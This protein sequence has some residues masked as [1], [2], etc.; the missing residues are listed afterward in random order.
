LFQI[1]RTS[2]SES[3]WPRRIALTL[4]AATFPLVWVGGLVTTYDAGMAVPDWPTTYGYNPLAYP[5]MTWLYGPWDLFIEHAH[6][7]LAIA[8]GMLTIALVVAVWRSDAR[9]SMR[10]LTLLTLAAV[11]A[12]GSLGGLRVILDDTQLAMLH[13]CVGPA[14]LALT[15]VVATLLSPRWSADGPRLP[16]GPARRMRSL[17][18]LSVTLA[19]GQLV[20]GAQLRHLPVATSAQQFH[21]LVV[22]H[23]I[24]AAVLIAQIFFLAIHVRRS[25]RR[26]SWLMRPSLLLVALGLVQISLGLGTWMAKY[27]WPAW[28]PA[29]EWVQAYTV[30]AESRWQAWVTT[31]HVATGA[32]IVA[33]SA[34]MLLR[35]FHV[36]SERSVA[37]HS[38][39]AS[40]NSYHGAISTRELLEGGM[41]A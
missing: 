34:V 11:I 4:V 32:L 41:T 33:T 6:R 35:S 24:T 29:Y 14:F 31:A 16:A 17:A 39:E 12:Q 21:T 10:C 1:A 26:E 27:G 38:G 5:W 8:V 37:T 36:R 9:R 15:A 25:A 13:G 19:Y 28:L 20:L 18:A 30:A 7:L 23:L 22:A 3:S 2:E 40:G